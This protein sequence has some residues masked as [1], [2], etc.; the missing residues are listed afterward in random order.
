M[1]CLEA[2]VSFL[3]YYSVTISLISSGV[4]CTFQWQYEE[5]NQIL[6]LHQKTFCFPNAL[7]RVTALHMTVRSVLGSGTHQ[8]ALQIYNS[9]QMSHLCSKIGDF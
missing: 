5:Q 7:V 4:T 3:C 9:S 6:Q 2:E 1:L 8:V